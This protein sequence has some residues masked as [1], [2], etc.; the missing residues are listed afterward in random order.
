LNFTGLQVQVFHLPGSDL[1]AIEWKE[2]DLFL[3][4]DYPSLLSTGMLAGLL[5]VACPRLS[6]PCSTVTML[7]LVTVAET[8]I[9]LNGKKA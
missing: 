1:L 8:F 9:H 5:V 3:F 6:L 2:V 4:V 7:R